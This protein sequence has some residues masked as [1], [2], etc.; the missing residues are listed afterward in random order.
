M[1]NKQKH[2]LIMKNILKDIYT[3][4]SISSLLGFKGGT[5]SY[6][7]YGLTRF[8]VDLDF[9]LLV[10]NKENIELII[11]KINKI[12]GKYGEI[13]DIST[14]KNT[15]FFLLS[16]GQ[17][18]RNIKVE[19]NTRELIKNIENYYESKE[20][21][22]IP[23]FIANKEYSFSSKLAAL[24]SRKRVTNRDIYD[25]YFYL[26]NNWNIDEQVIIKRTNKSVKEH[27]VDCLKA[28]ESIK[29][30]QI[31]EGLGDLIITEKEKEWIKANLIKET[32]FL[33]KNYISVL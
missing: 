28:I 8:S 25:I 22:G 4:V 26:K 23:M 31:L 19:I 14:K 20:I 9:D 5:C 21:L 12:I 27:L 6:F 17:D 13:K 24:T 7:F 15:L 11:E 3:D 33:I 30:N 10:V 32:V 16:Y 1:F 29:S 2:E 18:E